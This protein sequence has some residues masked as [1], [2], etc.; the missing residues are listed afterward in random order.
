VKAQVLVSAV[1]LAMCEQQLR[2]G[3]RLMEYLLRATGPDAL[4]AVGARTHMLAN[5][6]SLPLSPRVVRLDSL[7]AAARERKAKAASNANQAV[8]LYGAHH[9]ETRRFREQEKSAE[10]EAEARE[11]EA[12]RIQ[13]ALVRCRHALLTFCEAKRKDREKAHGF[14][15][16]VITK[17]MQ[18]RAHKLREEYVLLWKASGRPFGSWAPIVRPRPHALLVAGISHAPT[19]LFSSHAPS[20]PPPLAGAP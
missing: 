4:Y 9:P 6:S 11:R 5:S 16:T 13:S 12:H 7:A 19:H 3:A 1:K 14:L 17:Q 18:H 10:R 20:H 15:R 2:D 8:L